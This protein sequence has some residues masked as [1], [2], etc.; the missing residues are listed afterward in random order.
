MQG[1]SKKITCKISILPEL[2]ETSQC[3]KKFSSGVKRAGVCSRAVYH[4]LESRGAIHSKQG[5]RGKTKETRLALRDTKHKPRQITRKPTE[6]E[7]EGK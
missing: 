3:K 4:C 1:C 7:K 6:S 2:T 5:G